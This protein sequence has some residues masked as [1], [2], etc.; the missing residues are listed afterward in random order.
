MHKK[1]KKC[2]AN[3]I[4]II[5]HTAFKPT[6]AIRKKSWCKLE[7]VE[8]LTELMWN[9]KDRDPKKY[10]TTKDLVKDNDLI[11]EFGQCINFE[12]S[13]NEIK[14]FIKKYCHEGYQYTS[15]QEC[16]DLVQGE[17]IIDEEHELLE[18]IQWTDYRGLELSI[19]TH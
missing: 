17:D 11:D 7:H 5:I 13:S 4:I 1:N 8:K 12:M 2:Y 10:K 15:D 18:N 3:L 16:E 9:S 14:K 6:K 19:S